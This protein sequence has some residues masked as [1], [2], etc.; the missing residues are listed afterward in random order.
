MSI[1]DFFQRVPEISA[2]E[3]RRCIEQCRPDA[4]VL[5]DVRQPA[6]YEADHLPGA[7]NIPISELQAHLHELPLNKKILVY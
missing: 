1:F 4:Y 2:E 7:I 5:L 3:V 6:E